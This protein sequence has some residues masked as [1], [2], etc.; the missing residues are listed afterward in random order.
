MKVHDPVG[1]ISGTNEALL[2]EV[3]GFQGRSSSILSSSPI[4]HSA[5]GDGLAN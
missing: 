1:W 2:N 4:G 5:L 3:I